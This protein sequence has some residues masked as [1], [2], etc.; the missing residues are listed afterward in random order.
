MILYER[1]ELLG[2]LASLQR[3]AR[4]G[5]GRLVLV[6]GEAGIGKTS[7]VDAFCREQP[8]PGLVLWGAC[9]AITPPRAFGPLADIAD[10]VGG[11]LAHALTASDRDGVLHAFLALLRR[12]HLVLVIEDIHWADDATLDLLRVVGRRL[13]GMAVLMI[14]TYREEEVGDDH[15]LRLALGDLPAQVV[16]EIK[17]PP[18]SEGAIETMAAGSDVDSAVLHAVTAGNPFFATEVI[19]AGT[20]R[21]PPSVRDAVLARASRLSA[22]AQQALRAAS[23]LG[24]RWEPELL[25][26]VAEC[27]DRSIEECR[28]RGML[29]D[30]EGMLRFR[31]DLA[32]RALAEALDPR[33]GIRLNARALTILRSG[34]T[35]VDAAR[36]ARHAVDAGDADAVLE[37]AARAGDRAAALGAHR[38]AAAHFESVPYSRSRCPTT[39]RYDHSC[40]SSARSWCEWN[41]R[42]AP[43]WRRRCARSVTSRS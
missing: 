23:V 13:R 15:P 40:G 19:A 9:D 27:D 42:T 12:R 22:P 1:A 8:A 25:R 14:G 39:T 16:S 5:P 3:D 28:S 37:F 18:L 41:D 4:R 32:Q 38:E 34:A 20:A 31:H 6:S 35:E 36:L 24:S 43:P 2:R 17:V 21:V 30:D 11:P 7:L 26:Q 33:E 29:T 10:I